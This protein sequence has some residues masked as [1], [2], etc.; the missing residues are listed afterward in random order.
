MRLTR[1][2]L[3]LSAVYAAAF[4][5]AGF[6]V[7]ITRLKDNSFFWHL[8]TGRLILDEGIPRVDPYSYTASGT[9][10]VAQS[11]LA[12]VTYGALDRAFGAY[13]IRCFTGVLGAMIALLAY[14]LA[15]RLCRDRLR[16][17][18][19]T[20]VALGGLYAQFSSRPLLVGVFLL[21]LLVWL[22][23]L[24]N[25]WLGRHEMVAVPVLLWLW[26]NVHG[27]FAL[28]FT[29]LGLHLV[30]RWIEGAPPWRR[31]ERRL[32]EGT[33]IAA[34]L[35]FVNPYGWRLV[36][37]P[38]TLLGR[39]EDLRRIVEWRSPNFTS[40]LGVLFA[41]WIVAF[42]VVVARRRVGWRD[43]L[44]AVPF[45][46]LGLW[47]LRN[48]AIA[49]L[50]S[51]PIAA[52]ALARPARETAPEERLPTIWKGVLA[53][54]TAGAIGVAAVAATEPDFNFAP[55]PVDAL[56]AVRDQGLE[57]RNLL[58]TD[59]TSGY[60][61]LTEWPR[62]LVFVDDRIDMYPSE[63]RG[64]YFALVDGDPQWVAALRDHD[65]EV[66]V[67][68]RKRALAQLLDESPEWER[69]YEGE[70]DDV[71]VRRDLRASSR[72]GDHRVAED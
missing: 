68:P 15:Y 46:L 41:A 66:V 20:V 27:T 71:W 16:A 50:V 14:L 40:L 33:A 4:A 17:G 35:A 70:T 2:P 19:L 30:G 8:R 26:A 65:V 63:V 29:Y 10:W 28:G 37:F 72:S 55:Y 51:L 11:W 21:L 22:V 18:I 62:Q 31:R 56:E 3:T 54:L 58:T 64:A 48:T 44:V 13:A 67:W 6:T 42:L 59:A 23:E 39:G 45:L 38:L 24:P 60:V 34:A 53:A 25:S 61:I 9:S 12:E 49:P 69:T 32:L 5:F 43:V 36:L 1:R 47:A 7:G 57:G 52:R